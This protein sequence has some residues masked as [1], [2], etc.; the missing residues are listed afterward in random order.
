MD[1][2][3]VIAVLDKYLPN[4][5]I[6]V[7]AGAYD[8]NDTVAMSKKWPHGKIYAF[9]PVPEIYKKLIARTS[10]IRNIRCFNDAL[11][12]KVGLADFIL[13]ER[14]DDPSRLGE[15]SS[16]LRPKEHLKYAPH[17]KFNKAIC[18]N[19]TTLDKW[20]E[21]NN[22]YNIDLL[23]LDLQGFELNVLKAAPNIMKT[24]KIIYT[25]LEFVEAYEGQYLFKDVDQWLK[26]NGFIRVAR[27]FSLP[28]KF[29]FGNAVYIREDCL[30][31]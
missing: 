1:P 31:K 4:N 20:A 5:P 30:R 23:W 11:S 13:S 15:S 2:A 19:A 24:V 17:V 10:I 29:W 6:I 26:K 3:H 22:I 18:V 28:V 7:E 14:I 21:D 27:D 8:G 25:E 12:D 16:L 9:E